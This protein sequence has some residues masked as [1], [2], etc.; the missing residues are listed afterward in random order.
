MSGSLKARKMP[1][2]PIDVEGRFT[3]DVIIIMWDEQSLQFAACL[4]RRVDL[5]LS[6]VQ[7]M[8]SRV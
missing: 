6:R 4:P 7:K 8:L 5:G 3:Y 2:M 1:D